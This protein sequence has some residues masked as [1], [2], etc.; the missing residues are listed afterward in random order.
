MCQYVMYN[1]DKSDAFILRYKNGTTYS[2][3]DISYLMELRL[4]NSSSFIVKQFQSKEGDNEALYF[5]KDIAYYIKAEGSFNLP[6]Y[7]FT[8]LGKE[9][10]TIVDDTNVNIDYLKEF[11]KSI[12]E[13]KS[14]REVIAGEFF[15]D[16]EVIHF[17]KN[18]K[19][20]E[21]LRNT[22]VNKKS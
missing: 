17:K 14:D 22:D 4:I 16:G 12:T 15:S 13:G 5:H 9:I 1:Y 8:K 20:F 3:E 2:F 6:I 21:I 19:Y 7:S 10:L 11:S 18:D